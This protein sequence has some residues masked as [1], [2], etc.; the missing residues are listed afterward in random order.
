MATAGP[1]SF[2]T[3]A[4]NNSI[5]TIS[6]TSTG[7]PGTPTCTLPFNGAQTHYLVL[8]NFGFSIPSGGTIQG[9]QVNST[10]GV[11][12]T[13]TALDNSVKIVKGG[14]IG[15]TD[16]A[17]VSNIN[18]AR[19]W[20]GSSN[21]WGLTWLYSD[22]N[23]STFGVAVC[24]SST[25]SGSST[26][27]LSSSN[28]TITVTYTVVDSDELHHDRRSISIPLVQTRAQ[29]SAYGAFPFPTGNIAPPDSDGAEVI[30]TREAIA[31]PQRIPRASVRAYKAADY[32]VQAIMP[33]DTDGAD[34]VNTRM[35]IWNP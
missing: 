34:A 1:N 2:G 35:Q 9:I 6:W 24:V 8:S 10:F 16:Q 22:I 25:G 18:G 12:G 33:S 30:V 28:L 17:A 13:L 20:G 31:I 26:V 23:A 4:D 19:T 11:S 7:S 32:P 15:G 27:T 29:T 3:S 21:L 5:G 14:S